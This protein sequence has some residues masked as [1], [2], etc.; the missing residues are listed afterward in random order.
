[1]VAFLKGDD[2]ILYLILFLIM[3]FTINYFYMHYK[4]R[5]QIQDETLIFKQK[6]SKLVNEFYNLL[7]S[8]KSL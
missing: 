3:I 6:N 1:M 7:T 2:F 4:I 8:K 5:K